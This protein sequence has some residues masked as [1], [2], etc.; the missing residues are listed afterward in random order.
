LIVRTV[1]ILYFASIREAVGRD[2][3]TRD[4]PAD[5]TTP[6]SLI[7]WLAG[8][9]SGYAAAFADLTRLRVAI[10]QQLAELNAPLGEASEIA[11]FPPVTGG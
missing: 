5:I 2:S 8:Q 10:D 3:E 6:R 1:T 7:D 11:F 4:I 9:S